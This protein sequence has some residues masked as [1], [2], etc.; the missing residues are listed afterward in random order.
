MLGNATAATYLPT[1]F[2]KRSSANT[3]GTPT[4]LTAVPHDSMNAAATA[5]V[6]TYAAAPT[7]GTLV[8]D[9]HLSA[10]SVSALTNASGVA[11]L[12]VGNGRD[13][14]RQ[15]GDLRQPIILR[16]AAEC[17]SVNLK[18]VA[19]PSGFVAAFIFEWIEV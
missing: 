14:V 5:V 8:G 11:G 13:A 2:T 1:F 3:G 7:T 9:V 19:L 10:S 6:N 15:V 18:G 17:L 12:F 4:A 16:G